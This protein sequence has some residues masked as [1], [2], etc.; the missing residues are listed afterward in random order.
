VWL[1]RLGAGLWSGARTGFAHHFVRFGIVG[2]FGLFWDTGTVYALR[3]F[4]GIYIAG[5]CGFL[6]AGTANWAFNRLWTFRGL[7]HAA[8]HRQLIAFLLANFIGF[9]VN[10]GIFFT[11]VTISLLCRNQPVIAIIAG[12]AGGLVFNYFLSKKYVFN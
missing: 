1:T 11:L 12:T 3:G 10:R 6:V 2:F 9:I 8:A 4:T 7:D 5:T